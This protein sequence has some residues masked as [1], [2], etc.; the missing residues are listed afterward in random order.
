MPTS[1]PPTDDAAGSPAREPPE[2][3]AVV[4]ADLDDD[5]LAVLYE[6]VK[7][8]A[9][10]FRTKGFYS[11]S[12]VTTD[13]A[14]ESLLKAFGRMLEQP[15]ESH[16]HLLNTISKVMYRL[17]C[18]RLRRRKARDKRMPKVPLLDHDA[19]TTS[20]TDWLLDFTEHLEVLEQRRNRAAEVLRLRAFFRMSLPEIATTLG[21]SP[22]A[23][24]RELAFGR[25]FLRRRGFHADAI[26]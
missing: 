4:L 5:A 3:A 26:P 17:L 20:D 6:Q 18:E 21:C 2:Q 13:L 19:R 24:Q 22:E 10:R 1:L 8:V 14:H 25:V 16:E 12:L 9:R 11:D 7:A 23:A 15:F